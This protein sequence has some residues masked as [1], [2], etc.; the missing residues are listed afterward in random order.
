VRGM[1]VLMWLSLAG[2][3]GLG[4]AVASG[5]ALSIYDLQYTTSADGGSPYEG[6]TVD[7]AGGIVT[8]KWAG[9]KKRLYL[10]DPTR[11]E[12]AAVMVK[13]WTAD[14]LWAN[15]SVG[16]ELALT[17]VYVEESSGNTTLR[18]DAASGYTVLSTGNPLPAPVV[19]TADQIAAPTEGPP[20]E[21]YVA[22]RSA[23]K[24]EHMLLTV[25][26][27]TVA[28]TGLGKAVDNYELAGAAG[29]CWA[30][31]YMNDTVG[32]NGYHPYVS[33][34]ASFES[35]SGVFE[36]YTKLSS[37][38]DYYQ[39]VTRSTDDLVVPAPAPAALLLAG[40]ALLMRRRR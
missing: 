32:V 5:E 26:N 36:Q 21:W 17:G 2:A 3:L 20:G 24:Y 35:L 19:V 37:G 39:L 10:Q 7:C 40:G 11:P 38:W 6:S 28:A 25:E 1:R 9:G 16:D 4:T 23:E 15:V 27:V 29:S 14:E 8:F 30:A 34:G 22:D 33:P 12:W 31:D 13:D 18:Y